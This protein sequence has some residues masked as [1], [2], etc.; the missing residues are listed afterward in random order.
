MCG[1][2]GAIFDLMVAR[3][4]ILKGQD[5]RDDASG[6]NK[7]VIRSARTGQGGG[8]APSTDS[9]ATCLDFIWTPRTAKGV[10]IRFDITGL[11]ACTIIR[12]EKRHCVDM[13]IVPLFRHHIFMV[14]SIAVTFGMLV[15]VCSHA[16]VL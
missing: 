15:L 4:H 12:N 16:P 13:S 14:L 3:G 11:L 5:R 9:Y 2:G 10:C 6:T 7:P 8:C 1:V